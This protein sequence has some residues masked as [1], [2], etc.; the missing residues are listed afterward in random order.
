MLIN[1]GDKPARFKLRGL[2]AKP[3][4]P[5]FP[6]AGGAAWTADAKGRHGLKLPAQSAQV[7]IES[8]GG[9]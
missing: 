8:A 9:P 3:W 6:A 5:V 4:K 7:W 1:Y 2:K